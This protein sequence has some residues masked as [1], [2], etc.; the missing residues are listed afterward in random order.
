MLCGFADYL[1]TL[2]C[3]KICLFISAE[4]LKGNS[5]REPFDPADIIENVFLEKSQH[6]GPA[7]SYVDRFSEDGIF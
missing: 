2:D 7:L 6:S 1:N 4:L 3:G 5:F